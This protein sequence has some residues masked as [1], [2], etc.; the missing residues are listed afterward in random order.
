MSDP[1]PADPKYRREPRVA[2]VP[3]PL[4]GGRDARPHWVGRDRLTGVPGT[5][6]VVSCAACGFL[7][8]SPRPIPE[9]L[10]LCY[11]ADYHAYHPAPAEGH[12]LLRG[13]GLRADAH[14]LVLANELGYP[15]MRPER[16]GIAVR[17]LAALRA[18]RVRKL[19]FPMRGKGRMLDVGCSTGARMASYAQLGWRVSG[20]ENSP[21]AAAEARR[22]GAEVFVGDLLDANY[23][24]R[25]F[26]LVT[27]FH[28]LEHVLDPRRAMRTMIDWLS[29]EGTLVVELPNAAGLG[30]RTFGTHWFLLDVPRHLH[31]F[32]PRTL[33]R[34]VEE[35]GGEVI[36]IEQRESV[37]TWLGSLELYQ[38]ERNPTKA[39]EIAGSKW[40]KRALRP[41]LGIARALG[42]GEILRAH[43]RRAGHGPRVL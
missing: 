34:L 43:I 28:V 41:I 18:P 15:A 10:H 39:K 2:A 40:R 37:G 30:A 20:I 3:C 31:H 9:D 1:A 24:A 22:G 5:F 14:R 29:D 17:L 11:P 7:Y 4:C 23:P 35:S 38:A 32:T 13:G 36:R 42:R 27:C 33:A 16:A 26:D 6:S 19:V 25:G 8:L 12:K 21:E